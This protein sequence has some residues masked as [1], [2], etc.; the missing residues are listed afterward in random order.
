MLYV[1]PP[2]VK[3]LLQILVAVDHLPLAVTN[4]HKHDQMDH[5]FSLHANGLV[6][7]YTRLSEVGRLVGMSRLLEG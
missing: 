5:H 6:S 1:Q 2:V 7:R 3:D 4:R